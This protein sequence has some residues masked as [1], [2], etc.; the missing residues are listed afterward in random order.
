MD[1]ENKLTVI[2]ILE[3]VGFYVIIAKKGLKSA[4]ME[5]ALYILP[6]A[7]NRIQNLTLPSIE[8]IEVVS[9]SLQG[10]RVKIVIPS[11]IIDIYTRL[12]KLL[13]LRLSGNNDTLTEISNL[14]EEL[15]K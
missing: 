2:S 8:N 3:N 9:D 5:D 14:I 13:G 4:R 11:N 12:K 6:K 10:E 1:D 15:Y 7:K